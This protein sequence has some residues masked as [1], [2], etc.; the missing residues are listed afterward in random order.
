MS[1][2]AAVDTK[3]MLSD[4]STSL[5]NTAASDGEIKKVREESL[6]NKKFLGKKYSSGNYN[7]NSVLS[8]IQDNGPA[9]DEVFNEKT[10]SSNKPNVNQIESNRQDVDILED[11]FQLS[12]SESSIGELFNSITRTQLL[13]IFIIS[14]VVVGLA[15]YKLDTY[16]KTSIQQ[17]VQ[18]VNTNYTV[19]NRQHKTKMGD[20][21]LKK[22]NEV[23]S[24]LIPSMEMLPIDIIPV[25]LPTNEVASIA[26]SVSSLKS[27]IYS[28][29]KELELVK[30]KI[31]ADKV[32]QKKSKKKNNVE[33]INSNKLNSINTNANA[34]ANVV[35]T[36]ISSDN[37]ATKDKKNKLISK[38]KVKEK[39]SGK[40]KK[41]ADNFKK[42]KKV[43]SILTVSLVS[44]SNENKA[45]EILERLDVSGLS[46]SLEKAVVNG[47]QVYRISVSGFTDLD[48]AKLFIHS[49]ADKYGVKGSKI[50]NN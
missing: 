46:P 50:R 8:N 7:L 23:Q 49:A 15:M 21:F 43:K 30:D 31:K 18:N 12:S 29:R 36:N 27:E 35:S 10:E 16:V 40:D 39:H 19:V 20:L 4:F 47:K 24:S 42:S 11:T 34:N 9:Y 48:E 25:P 22:P 28:L 33:I 2:L 14:I 44:L 5:L 26:S 6:K 45:N 1:S 38:V 37:V 32:N 13:L 17:T 41:I 3:S